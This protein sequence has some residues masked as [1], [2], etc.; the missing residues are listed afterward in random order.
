MPKERVFFLYKPHTYSTGHAVLFSIGHTCY[1]YV[2]N[3]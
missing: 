1:Y 3:V 2:Y